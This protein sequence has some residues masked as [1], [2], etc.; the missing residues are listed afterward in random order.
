MDDIRS[1]VG[2]WGIPYLFIRIAVRGGVTP[3][4]LA[5][6]RVTLAAVFL[7]ALAW[8][9][10]TLGQVRGSVRWLV[11]HAIA[12]V[13]FPFPLI[14]FGEQRVASSLAA[15]VIAAVPLIGAVL[16]LRYD[17]SERPT[18]LRAIGLLVGFAS[19]G[20]DRR[21]PGGRVGA[22]RPR[23][24]ARSSRQ[25]AVRGRGRI[26][27]RARPRLHRGRV[28]DL[29]DPDPRGGHEPRDRDHL[30]QPGRHRGAR[31]VAQRRRKPTFRRESR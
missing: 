17:P 9:A 29:H 19:A 21:E 13:T 6:G 22:A 14:A 8:K 5:W 25:G 10:G 1:D 12:E 28:R 23:R 31:R 20:D 15:I 27:D 11:V 26:G 2:I 4:V 24:G 18:P 16:A 7:L 30:R 3:L